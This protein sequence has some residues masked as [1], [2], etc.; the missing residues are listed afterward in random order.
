MSNKV[1]VNLLNYYC[2]SKQ[3]LAI[4][5]NCKRLPFLETI[6]FYHIAQSCE[7]SPGKAVAD[8]FGHNL[9]KM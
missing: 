1:T 4:S 7:G 6:N 8:K 2:P 5:L 9:V 3:L